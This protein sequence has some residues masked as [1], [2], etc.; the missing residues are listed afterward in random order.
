MSDNDHSE[1]T[2]EFMRVSMDYLKQ[3]DLTGF[4]REYKR[5]N[6]Y[7]QETGLPQR[8]LE[9]VQKFYQTSI[10]AYESRAI[11]KRQLVKRE[12]AEELLV[13][14]GVIAEITGNEVE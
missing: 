5:F 8:H 7:A 10:A 6:T 4:F 12:E 13:R 3:G 2:L 11:Q 14:A 9:T 1:R